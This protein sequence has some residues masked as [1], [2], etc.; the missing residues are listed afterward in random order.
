VGEVTSP[1]LIHF[2]ELLGLA[3]FAISGALAAGRKQLDWLG[4]VVIATV[5]AIGGGTVRDL[6]LDRHPVAWIAHPDYLWVALAAAFFTLA[7]VRFRQPPSRALLIADALGLALFTLSG[8]QIA[9]QAGAHGI[10]VVVMGTIT[11]VVGGVLRDVLTGE[12]PLIL[13]D[14]DIYATAAIAGAALYLLLQRLGLDR[15][16]AALAGMSIVA[17]LRLA[18]I[19]WHLKMPVF[20]YQDKQR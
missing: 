14:Q 6:L 10:I 18:A 8:A 3:V 4:M 15:D 5:T 1:A 19:F 11:G 9:E 20:S 17:A 13:R 16:M 2:A 12:I 7:Y